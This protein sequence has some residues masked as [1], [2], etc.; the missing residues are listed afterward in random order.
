MTVIEYCLEKTDVRELVIIR[1]G[2]YERRVAYIDCEDLF[3]RP[4]DY[5]H[6]DVIDFSYGHINVLDHQ[7]AYVSVPCTYLDIK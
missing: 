2:G 6:A 3:R 5:A 1:S 4:P 7:G